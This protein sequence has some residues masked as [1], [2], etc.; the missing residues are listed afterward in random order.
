MFKPD[1]KTELFLFI[2][3]P[4]G[5]VHYAREHI[6]TAPAWVE[7]AVQSGIRLRMK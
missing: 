3:A 7:G 4:E 2:H 5:R 1:Q 6:S